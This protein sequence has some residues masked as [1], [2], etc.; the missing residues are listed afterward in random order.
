MG[1]ALPILLV[2]FCLVALFLGK[3]KDNFFMVSTYSENGHSDVYLM[4]FSR[5]GE[6]QLINE[7]SVWNNPSYF[8]Q[9]SDKTIYMVN[10][11]QSFAGRDGGGISVMRVDHRELNPL[12]GTAINQGGGGPCY[13]ALTD[14]DRYIISANYGSGSVSVVSLNAEGIPEKVTDT[15]FFDAPDS[16]VSHP[17]MVFYNS[18][19]KLY[20]VTDL[21]LDRIYLFSFDA[22]AGKLVAAATPFIT[23]EKGSGPRHM[24]TDKGEKNLFVVNE[25]GSTV[26]VFDITGEV[27]VLRQTI[28]A[29]PEG[30]TEKNYSGDIALSPSGR[31]L[32]VT[33]R[34]DNSLAVFNVSGGTLE[35]AGHVSCGGNW[36]RNMAISKD[37]KRIIVCNQRSGD[38][39]FFRVNRKTGMPEP[40]E[41]TFRLNAPSCVKFL[42]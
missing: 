16:V 17:H 20:Y 22:V 1:S 36:P 3:R 13:L 29:L 8:T 21:G 2:L 12:V 37:G 24:V 5:G 23:V 39:A 7:A 14:D 40:E 34:G 10:E 35:L 42:K 41:Y 28:S 4:G 18:T 33:N 30:F 11:V 32:Y 9:A 27:P 25:L 15:I 38:L 26:T 6:P 31:N 19:K